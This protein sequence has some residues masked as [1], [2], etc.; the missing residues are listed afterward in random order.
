MGPGAVVS[1]AAMVILVGVVIRGRQ[2]LRC[3]E[4]QMTQQ[5]NRR[6]QSIQEAESAYND[7]RLIKMVD[8]CR[9]LEARVQNRALLLEILIEDADRRI[10]ALSGSAPDAVL[11]MGSESFKAEFMKDVAY[12]LND[13]ALAKKYKKTP[14]VMRLMR[15]LWVKDEENS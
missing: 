6:S 11:P 8:Y 15:E 3:L 14:L 1:F 2:R 5:K 13:E 9:Q 12:G 10:E 4:A 7:R